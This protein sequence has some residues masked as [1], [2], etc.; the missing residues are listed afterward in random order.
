LSDT[1]SNAVSKLSP[2]RDVRLPAVGSGSLVVEQY[3]L[4]NPAL[5]YAGILLRAVMPTTLHVIIG[6][7]TA[8]AVGT[9]FARRN[10]RTWLRCAGS[11][12]LIA[13][14]GKLLPLFALFF[15]LLGIEAL[16]LH[17]GFQLPYHGNVPMMVIAAMLFIVAYQSLAALIVLLVRNLALSLS[18]VAIIS[19]PAFGYAGVGLPVL[20]MNG[21]AKAW[22]RCCR[23]A[24]IN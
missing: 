8:Y 6:I 14:V 3:V 9:E 12:P 10:R 17:A 1:I 19:S 24:G 15:A 22:G 11:S 20:A 16:I 21:F 4:T 7:A 5:N 23:Y 18:L 13:L 2:L